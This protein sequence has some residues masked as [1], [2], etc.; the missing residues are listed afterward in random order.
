MTVT[1]SFEPARITSGPGEAAA[2]MLRLTNDAQAREVVRLRAA[3]AL[4]DRM[5]LQADTVHLGPGEVFEI[6]VVV[7]VNAELP[8]GPHNSGI[9]V[10]SESGAT[11]SA[12]ATIDVLEAPAY[13][14]L[15]VPAR[16]RSGKLGRHR[17]HLA[18][19]GNAVVFVE[20]E[21]EAVDESTQIDLATPAVTLEPGTEATV[22]VHVNP[23][24][25]FWSGRDVEH[26]FS[27]RTSGSDGRIAELPG[28]FEQLPRLRPWVLPAV[29]G[30]LGALLVSTLA[31]FLLLRPD[32]ENIAEDAAN[33]AVEA[34]RVVLRQLIAQLEASAAEAEELPL[35]TPAD[36]RLE[37]S[38]PPGGTATE[39]FVVSSGR[40]LSVTDVV[41][42]NPTGAVG[43]VSLLRNGD[44]LLES[45]LA[46]FRDLDFHFVA[47]F[48]YEGGSTVSIELVCETPGP[49]EEECTV[50]TSLAGFADEE[51]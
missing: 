17:V 15:L 5:V 3:G 22:D 28:E 13:E 37:A 42:Q 7:D 47:P 4:A 10:S 26:H 14:A 18:N 27:I 8:A 33:D 24:S 41:F 49:D 20:L 48:A 32:V 31:W 6:P 39:S 34:D 38:A 29:L 11:S 25:V 30:M 9:E 40:V 19:R 36:L 46:N 44:V 43:R 1:A 2:L 12:E 50:G 35:G 51:R 21:A 45:D 16:S 23:P